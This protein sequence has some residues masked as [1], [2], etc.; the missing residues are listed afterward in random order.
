[1]LRCWDSLWT[2]ETVESPQERC[3]W[4]RHGLLEGCQLY[5]LGSKGPGRQDLCCHNQQCGLVRV[6][7]VPSF[8]N[9]RRLKQVGNPPSLRRFST[10]SSEPHMIRMFVGKVSCRGTY[11]RDISTR[12]SPPLF[13]YRFLCS[14]DTFTSRIT[15][16][17][18]SMTCSPQV[19]Q[20]SR[21]PEADG[22]TLHAPGEE[23]QSGPLLRMLLRAPNLPCD[24]K[25]FVTL[26]L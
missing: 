25:R 1:M 14:W 10:S 12:V 18:H 13:F 16:K 21:S 2:Q 23:L 22:G 15:I 3:E 9:L 6:F 5:R 11:T 26:S 24:R 17:P 20:G 19:H 8:A 4:L 7:L